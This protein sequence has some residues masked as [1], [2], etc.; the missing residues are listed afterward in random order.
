MTFARVNTLG[1]ALFEE[2]TSAQMNAL[3]ID[4]SN[5]VDG[6][7][8]GTYGL[9][10]QL[11]FTGSKFSIVSAFQAPGSGMWNVTF[12]G[13]DPLGVADS[14]SAINAAT[15]AAA[16]T[17]GWV[18]FPSGSYKHNGSL[19]P[20]PG[21]SW[22]GAPDSTFININHA[23]LSQLVFDTGSS[24]KLKTVFEGLSF[25]ALVDNTGAAIDNPF[26]TDDVDIIFHRCAWNEDRSGSS[27]KLKGK[28]LNLRGLRSAFEFFECT[29]IEKGTT[30]WP[31]FVSGTECVCRFRSSTLVQGASSTRPYVS[32]D[33]GNFEA[34]NCYF[35]ARLHGLSA[36]VL[37]L[38]SSG[39]FILKGNTFESEFS[40]G[41]AINLSG[42]Q[43]CHESDSTFITIN[44]YAVGSVL[45]A[46]SFLSLSRAIATTSSASGTIA[47]AA[48]YRAES[49]KL[50]NAFGGVGPS[51]APPPI[52]FIGQ[53]WELTVYNNSGTNWTS[54]IVL[55][56]VGIGD[57]S[58]ATNNLL[59]RA[60]RLRALDVKA[61]GTPQWAQMAESTNAY[62]PL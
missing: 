48:G 30:D 15:A 58:G 8:G 28:L 6:L 29:A 24:G 59:A 16:A 61:T 9:L 25:G 36:D 45:A 43:F 20:Q 34:F 5:A 49:M 11:V 17:G 38:T 41:K 10:S 35:D 23:T 52:W 37:E 19:H 42:G 51:I 12:F 4:H 21:V 32:V 62:A 13:A 53:E 50:T 54:G 46:G 27:P 55:S 57:G 60:F 22:R 44:P 47:A 18:W 14:T 2:L 39:R 33:D 3:D 1:W 31:F 7:N 26:G 56:P 40:G